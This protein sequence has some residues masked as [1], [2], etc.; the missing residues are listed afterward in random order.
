MTLL[1]AYALVALIADEPA[2]EEVQRLLR[3]GECGVVVANLAE[4]IDISR[5]V[6]ALPGEEVR[7]AL[8]PL[9]VAG[10]LAAIASHEDDAWLAAELRTKHYDRKA[11]PLSMAD[12][13]LLAHAVAGSDEIATA[14]P[15]L[16]AVAAAEAVEVVRLPDSGGV[17]P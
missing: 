1:D 4:A 11:C 2:A 8:E 17:R 9:L 5:R 12:C 13:L 15:P 16:A 3:A 10:V 14:D 6:H 7:G